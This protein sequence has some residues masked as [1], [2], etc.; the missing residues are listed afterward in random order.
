MDKLLIFI[1]GATLCYLVY[2][3]IQYI[4]NEGFFLP[5]AIKPYYEQIKCRINELSQDRKKHF[6]YSTKE[7]LIDINRNKHM[8]Y[9]QELL[10]NNYN[11]KF[12]ECFVNIYLY[13]NLKRL[14]VSSDADKLVKNNLI[15]QCF[16]Q[17]ENY[18]KNKEKI[19]PILIE[20]L[21]EVYNSNDEVYYG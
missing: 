10:N 18:F 11:N 12:V 2:W 17:C 6:L 14:S 20:I 7:Y 3:V 15:K 1:G 8:R 5:S 4:S 16:K 13:S 9:N 21:E 19:N